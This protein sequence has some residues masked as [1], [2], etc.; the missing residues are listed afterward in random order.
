MAAVSSAARTM[1]IG[2]KHDGIEKLELFSQ[3][4][5]IKKSSFLVPLSHHARVLSVIQAMVEDFC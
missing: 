3:S 5:R 4:P 1:N 2:R